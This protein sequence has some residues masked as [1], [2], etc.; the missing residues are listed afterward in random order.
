MRVAFVENPERMAMVPKLFAR[1][2]RAYL[3]R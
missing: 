2:L 3:A 1:L